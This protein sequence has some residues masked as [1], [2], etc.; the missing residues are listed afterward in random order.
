MCCG[1]ESVLPVDSL[2][3]S[4]CL[5]GTNV[6]VPVLPVSMKDM[7][8]APCPFLMGCYTSLTQVPYTHIHIPMHAVA[9]LACLP[10]AHTGC[11]V[12]R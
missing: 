6:F 3:T 5:Q 2:A 4:H 11:T 8:A 7:L 12:P 1:S 9:V 10:S